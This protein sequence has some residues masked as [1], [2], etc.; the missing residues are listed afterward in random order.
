MINLMNYYYKRISYY[1]HRYYCCCCYCCYS[2]CYDCY[3]YCCYY[4]YCCCYFNLMNL[5][6]IKKID[7]IVKCAK[8]LIKYVHM[9]KFAIKMNM[10][11]NN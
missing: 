5:N 1:Y 3:Y 2:C 9:N 6:L 4:C 8:F 7:Y 11:L 10:H